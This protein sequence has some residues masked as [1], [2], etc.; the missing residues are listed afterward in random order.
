[1]SASYCP[2]PEGEEITEDERSSDTL[3]VM[4]RR[5]DDEHG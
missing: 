2:L 5:D 4:L 3:L 1:M